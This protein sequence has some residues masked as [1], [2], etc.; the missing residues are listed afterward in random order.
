MIKT[1]YIYKITNT[2]NGVSYIGQRKNPTSRYKGSIE[3]DKYFG[4]GKHLKLSIK[5]YGKEFF[6]KEI[7]ISDIRQQKLADELEKSMI[8]KYDTYN[9]GYNLTE[10]G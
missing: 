9:N 6:I 7:L 8:I 3:N 4:S 2:I 1:W 10:G 5:K